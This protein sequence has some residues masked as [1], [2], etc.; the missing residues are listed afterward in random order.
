[1]RVVAAAA[2]LLVA[3]QRDVV[4]TCGDNLHGVWVTPRGQRWMF[5]DNGGT[6][7]GYPLF[8][9]SVP[10]G[11]P[12]VM[13]LSRGEQLAGDI[14]RRYMRGADVCDAR[15]P[16]RITACKDDQLQLVLADVTS[17]LSFAPCAFGQPHPS[18]VETWKRD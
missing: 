6:L 11:A 10:D 7:E 15:A 9:D 14:K 16:V 3:C 13:D 5:I 12:R 2:L 8:D 18:R 1:M 4:A 17:P